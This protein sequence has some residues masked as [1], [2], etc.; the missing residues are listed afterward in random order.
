MH[1]FAPHIQDWNPGDPD[2]DSLDTPETT[3]G[4]GIIGA[5]NYLSE[6][7][8]NSIY[9]LPMN[10]GGDAQDTWPYNDPMIDGGGDAANDNTRFD[11]SKL[12]QWDV[13]FEHAQ[14]KGLMLHVVLNEAEEP[15][16][17]EL[18][19]AELGTERRLFYRELI[20]RFGHH[21]AIVWT[22]SEEYN[23]NFNIGSG[24]VLEFAEYLKAVDPFDRPVTVHNAGNPFNPNSG[25]WAPF[26]GEESIDLTSLQRARRLDGW[27]DVIADYRAASAAA[28]KPIPVMIDEPGSPTRDAGGDLNEFRKRVVWDILLSGGGGEWFINDRD[29]SLEDFRE[30]DQLWRETGYALRFINENLPVGTM[31]PAD[32]IMFFDEDLFGGAEVFAKPG[33]VY[34]MYFPD[35]SGP[36]GSDT[37]G[38]LDLTDVPGSFRV[39]W[40]NPRTGQFEGAETP[41]QGGAPAPVGLPPSDVTNDWVA[42]MTL[43]TLQDCDGDG[44]PDCGCPADLTN[45]DA[46]GG[47]D[48]VASLSDYQFFL[49]L[50]NAGHTDADITGLGTCDLGSRDG[51]VDLSDLV[52]Y[53]RLWAMGCP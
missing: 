27:G 19:S 8:V 25:P 42:L 52:C 16:K 23:L 51:A 35:A 11:L 26:I 13:V 43:V 45:A 34:A 2:W 49:A 28:G 20:A 9:F 31:A 22:I 6:T 53:L 48:G 29:Q 44:V 4:R 5:L 46:T 41:V 36:G 1:R 47:P 33:A 39:R 7:G 18:D 40:F 21:N 10:I 24:R 15:N 12:N 50:W 32:D 37:A 3:D 38:I 30:F 17:R 14:R